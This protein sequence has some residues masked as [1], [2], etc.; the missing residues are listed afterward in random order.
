[1]RG[2]GVED[3]IKLIYPGDSTD[4]HII[5]GSAYY[6][7]FRSHCITENGVA[8]TFDET[9]LSSNPF[10]HIRNQGRTAAL[11]L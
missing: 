1:M 4:D 9:D 11:W 3:I 6:K 2:S 10:E 8:S 5:K 7:T